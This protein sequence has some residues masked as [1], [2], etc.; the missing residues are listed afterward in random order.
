MWLLR[1][2]EGDLRLTLSSTE[3]EEKQLGEAPVLVVPR[4]RSVKTRRILQLSLAAALVLVFYLWTYWP[5]GKFRYRSLLTEVAPRIPRTYIQQW[6]IMRPTRHAI[7]GNLSDWPRNPLTAPE[8]AFSGLGPAADDVY[9]SGPR[10]MIAYE[11]QLTE[12]INIFPPQYRS[13]LTLG[14]ERYLHNDNPTEA[15]DADSHKHI[16]QTDKD[17]SSIGLATVKSWSE[18]L[19]VEQYGWVHRLLSDSDAAAMARDEWRQERVTTGD[20]YHLW[21]AL[22]LGILVRTHLQNCVANSRKRIYS[23]ICCYCS[24][25]VYTPI[26]IPVSSAFRPIGAVGRRYGRT[27]KGG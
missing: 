20:V 3:D 19:T 15:W 2:P 4:V 14:L 9:N 7:L 22:P 5:A 16:W 13:N 26:P 1:S 10:D 6:G 12:F 11:A 18:G 24:K 23:D 8:V 27:A 21:N 25:A 17:G